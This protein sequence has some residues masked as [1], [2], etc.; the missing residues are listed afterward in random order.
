M[1]VRENRTPP[2]EQACV[3]GV[4]DDATIQHERAANFDFHTV[5]AAQDV[6]TW[7]R[8]DLKIPVPGQEQF[9][10]AAELVGGVPFVGGSMAS[11]MTEK[12]EEVAQ[13]FLDAII[14]VAT[15]PGCI[16]AFLDPILSIDLDDAMAL[17]EGS[18]RA[19]ARRV[20]RRSAGRAVRRR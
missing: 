3:D 2:I 8:D 12:V 17:C 10:A 18:R 6:G 1:R 14:A 20:L 4:E 9:D 11:A 5:A 15:D 16:K 19:G 7:A 13:A